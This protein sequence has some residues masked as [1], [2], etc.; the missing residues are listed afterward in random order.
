MT[1]LKCK[2]RV[3]NKCGWEYTAPDSMKGVPCLASD[4]CDGTMCR[5]IEHEPLR[6]VAGVLCRDNDTKSIIIFIPGISLIDVTL[7]PFG[8]WEITI[9]APNTEWTKEQ[10]KAQYGKLPRKGSKEAVIIE[11]S[12][13]Q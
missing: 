1:F 11:L 13:E 2:K 6:Q 12:D 10:W 7:D 8:M 5:V 4:Q 9:T 3:C